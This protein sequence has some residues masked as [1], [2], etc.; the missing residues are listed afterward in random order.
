MDFDV[1]SYSTPSIKTLDSFL[2]KAG[3]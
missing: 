1:S 3:L 2:G